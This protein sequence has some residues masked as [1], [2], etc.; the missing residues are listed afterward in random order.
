MEICALNEFE[1]DFVCGGSLLGDVLQI[2]GSALTVVGIA[3]A[4]VATVAGAAVASPIV[5][6]AAAAAGVGAAALGLG[7]LINL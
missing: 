4:T 3:A 6:G 2:G 7:M 1:L 5:V